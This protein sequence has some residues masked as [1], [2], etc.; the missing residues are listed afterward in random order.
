KETLVKCIGMM[1]IMN[2]MACTPF[3]L[4]WFDWRFSRSTKEGYAKR[5]VW[6]MGC[7][8]TGE[9]SGPIPQKNRNGFMRR[10]GIQQVFCPAATMRPCNITYSFF[11]SL[12]DD[13][14]GGLLNLSN[15][16]ILLAFVA[17]LI[18]AG[19]YT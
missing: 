11:C 14:V 8:P 12:L 2:P 4:C 6:D 9:T 13:L 3:F 10:T 19:Q 15:R 17:Q 7:N 16:L 5:R 18:V 1:P